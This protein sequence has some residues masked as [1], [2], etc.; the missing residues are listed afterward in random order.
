MPL[1]LLVI[2]QVQADNEKAIGLYKKLG[3]E[4]YGFLEKASLVGEKLVNNILMKKEIR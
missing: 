2:I 1:D 3:F 4:Q